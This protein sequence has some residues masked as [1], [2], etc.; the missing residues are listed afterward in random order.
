MTTTVSVG[1]ANY[2]GSGED[3]AIMLNSADNALYASKRAGRNQTSV[4]EG[5]D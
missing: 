5:S 1:V 4:S 3:Y 2:P